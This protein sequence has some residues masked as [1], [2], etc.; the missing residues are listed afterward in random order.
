M[1]TEAL[2]SGDS[3]PVQP[4]EVL[5][6]LHYLK[7]LQWCWDLRRLRESITIREAL[8]L[9]W[10]D[11]TEY[12]SSPDFTHTHR[13]TINPRSLSNPGINP[14]PISPIP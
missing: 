3:V 14:S 12:V 11:R 6:T 5:P 4:Q 2:C 13:L 1:Q 9:G 8:P 10:T 7:G